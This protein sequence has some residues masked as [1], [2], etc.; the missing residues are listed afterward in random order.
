MRVATVMRLWNG[1][2]AAGGVDAAEACDRV[3]AAEWAN[4]GAGDRASFSLRVGQ[5]L[6]TIALRWER[7]TFCV[8]GSDLLTAPKSGPAPKPQ[9]PK[10]RTKPKK[11]PG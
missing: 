4:L 8:V 6:H 2:R 10:P 9:A 11:R 1:A 5:G 3:D 7:G